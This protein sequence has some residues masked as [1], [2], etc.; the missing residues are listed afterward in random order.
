MNP[1]LSPPSHAAQALAAAKKEIEI[2]SSLQIVSHFAQVVLDVRRRVLESVRPGTTL[3][4]LHQ[5]SVRLLSEG[6]QQLRILPGM[7]IDAIA[8]QHYR[9]VGFGPC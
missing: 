7:S 8:A 1:F 3:G 9:C 2:G 5:L 6:L 4:R